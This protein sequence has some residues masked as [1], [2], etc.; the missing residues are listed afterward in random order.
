MI[1][2]PFC[3]LVLS[4]A[5]AHFILGPIGWKIG[6]VISSVVYAGISGSFKVI[7]GA[8]FACICPAGH[9]RPASYLYYD[10]DLAAGEYRI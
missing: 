3:S 1:V 9:Y 10:R 7:F 4:V 6:S 2:V 8:I 5:A